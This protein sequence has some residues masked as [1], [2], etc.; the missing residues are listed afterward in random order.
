VWVT[1]IIQS[2]LDPS[3][4]SIDDVLKYQYDLSDEK[5]VEEVFISIPQDVLTNVSTVC[6]KKHPTITIRDV[7]T[8]YIKNQAVYDNLPTQVNKDSLNKQS[9]MEEQRRPSV[10]VSYY[11]RIDTLDGKPQRVLV[12]EEKSV[13]KDGN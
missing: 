5:S 12:K 13:V 11:Y 2:T 8:E 6:L 9:A 4:S 10:D 3:F 1:G 7:I